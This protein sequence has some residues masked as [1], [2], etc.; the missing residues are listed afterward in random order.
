MKYRYVAKVASLEGVK[1]FEATNTRQLI[2]ELGVYGSS[3]KLLIDKKDCH[4][5]KFVSIDR[6][7]IIKEPKKKDTFKI[8]PKSKPKI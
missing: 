1:T 7:E 3:I 5:A 6:F 8:K 4:A 2:K